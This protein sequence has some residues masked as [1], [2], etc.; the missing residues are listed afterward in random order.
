MA[1]GK[2]YEAK[3]LVISLG[4]NDYITAAGRTSMIY[5]DSTAGK[6]TQLAAA[7]EYLCSKY[8][9]P[10]R[11]I[12][13]EDSSKETFF[14]LI[15][16]GIVEA[17]FIS[18]ISEPTATIRRL[19]RGEWISPTGEWITPDRGS[20]CA[21]IIEGASSIAEMLQESNRENGRFLGEQDKNSHVEAGETLAL[22]GKFSYGFVQMELIRYMKSFA[23]IPGIERVLWSA[24]ESS[25]ADYD[26]AAM[27][28]PALV[29]NAK[30]KEISKY[31]GMLLH[32]DLLVKGGKRT[33]RLHLES[34][35]DPKVPTIT[36]P[37]K[38]TV[39][40]IVRAEFLKRLGAVDGYI[41][42]TVNDG[43][44]VNSLADVLRVSDEIMSE[45]ISK[46]RTKAG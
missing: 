1:S 32:L 9:K 3:P 45:L 4:D 46:Y 29:G 39:P 14:P 17:M 44:L 5:G 27:R 21:Y 18:K 10:V 7:A 25:G 15:A 23:M 13:A 12:S 20:A 37:A 41:D 40:L 30:T 22:P 24:H 26:G 6:T 28:G 11:L 38:I 42:T 2:Q 35:P 16:A 36:S 31:C 33:H 43:A 8:G 34:H 19:S